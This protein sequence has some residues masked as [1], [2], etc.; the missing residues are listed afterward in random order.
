MIIKRL[1]LHGFKSFPEKTRIAFH[2]GIT[3]IIGPNGTGKSNIVDALLWVLGGKRHKSLRNERGSEIIFNGSQQKAPM[4]MADVTLLLSE[5][6]EE[7]RINHRFF[8]SGESE[9]RLDGKPVR[10]KDIHEVLWKKSIGA[11]DYFVIEQGAVGLFLSSKPQEKRALLEEA[12]GTAFYRDRKHEAQRKLERS[13]ENLTRLEDIIAEVARSKNSLR[14]QANAAIRYR[15]LRERVRQL[16]LLHFRRKIRDFE[17]RHEEALRLYTENRDRENRLMLRLREEENLLA[18]KRREAWDLE[19]AIEE[20]REALHRLK[21]GIARTDAERAQEARKLDFC[22]EKRETASRS[23]EEAARELLS[24]EKTLE[25]I[26]VQTRSLEKELIRKTGELEEKEKSTRS[27][28]EEM[29]SCRKTVEALK[30]EHLGLLSRLTELN[31]EQVRT[32]KERELTLK[33]K[34]R[35]ESRL[36]DEQERLDET[37]GALEKNKREFQK[38]RAQLDRLEDRAGGIRK[39]ITEA[40]SRKEEIQNQLAEKSAEKDLLLRQVIALEKMEEAERSSV[41][42]AEGG[43][44]PGLLADLI[45]TDDAHAPLVDV[46]WKEETRAMPV[47][48]EAFL[49][50]LSEQGLRGN[51]LFLHPRKTRKE[52]RPPDHHLVLGLLKQHVRP[53]EEVRHWFPGLPDAV[54]VRDME[55]AVRLWLEHPGFHYVTLAGDVLLSSGLMK[56]GSGR[57]GLV[58]LRREKSRLQEK[59][60]R[61]AAE[62]PP[63]KSRLEE[64]DKHGKELEGSLESLLAQMEGLRKSV[65]DAEREKMLLEA[66]AEKIRAGISLIEKEIGILTAEEEELQESLENLQARTRKA[67]EEEAACSTRIL[68]EEQK[69]SSLLDHGERNRGDFFGLRSSAEILREKTRHL[70]EQGAELENRMETLRSKIES[71]D[72]EI[73]ERRREKEKIRKNILA[74][75]E[76]AGRK[77]K[78]LEEKEGR[79]ARDEARLRELLK[80]RQALETEVEAR[81]KE[82]ETSKEERVKWEIRKAER[83]RDLSNLEESCWQELKKTLEEVKKEISAEEA[84]KGDVDADL[85]EAREKLQGFSAVNLMAEEEYG[86]Q[87]QRHDFLVKEREDLHHSI[88]STREAIRKIDQESKARF[89][90]ALQEVNKYF[91]EIFASLF[92]GGQAEVKLSDPDHPLESGVEI[93]VQ[94]PGKRMQSMNLLSGGE[95]SLTS[96]AFF[97]SLFRYKPAPFCLLDEVDA[98]L[99]EVNLGRFL[100]LMKKVKEQTQFILITHNFKTMEVADY[101]YGTTM[102]EPNVTTVYSM[103]IDAKEGRES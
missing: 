51:F 17:T 68:A 61:L 91:Q 66:E 26:L 10:L 14:R 75:D 101:I 56:P 58:T 12:S 39:R 64:E 53:R 50:L 22:E 40:L 69:L 67:R 88:A 54:L 13:E 95:R 19:K 79:L 31:N 65:E 73:A 42:S 33:Q 21:T 86:R 98:A 77:K 48:A 16:T 47:E 100:N 43:R 20:E 24:L 74:L 45:E 23:R 30:E 25:K 4:S 103:K 18:S 11:K 27:L 60:E 81:R 29:A 94:P 63:L 5:E 87:K 78:E 71:L 59:K 36:S 83:E 84:D 72:R 70:K 57:E 6:D 28:E 96:L 97:F 44:A 62:I 35:A 76:E 15:K 32:E 89:L 8:R 90:S 38:L 34:E 93:A 92:E 82:A 52:N 9:Y 1:D 7:I 46:F 85:E 49:E 102:A 37:V 55:S 80:E 99:D 3:V 2:P 41:S